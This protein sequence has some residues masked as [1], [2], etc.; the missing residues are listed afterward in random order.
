MKRISTPC[1]DALVAAGEEPIVVDTRLLLI[2]PRAVLTELCRRLGL[3]F[4]EAMLSWPAGPKPEDGVW[5]PYWYDSVK[6]STGFAP[7]RPRSQAL[8][9]HLEPIAE[10]C[11]PHYEAL[12]ARRV[13][14]VARLAFGPGGQPRPWARAAACFSRQLS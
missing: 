2:D 11:E 13:R 4:D 9:A 14:R 8:P 12:H 5:A 6:E 1:S 3:D 7:Y 10:R